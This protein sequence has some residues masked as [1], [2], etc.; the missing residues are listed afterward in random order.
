MSTM[1]VPPSVAGPM[2]TRW[3]WRAAPDSSLPINLN[4]APSFVVVRWM[5]IVTR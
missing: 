2:R 4:T 1:T 5:R 3:S